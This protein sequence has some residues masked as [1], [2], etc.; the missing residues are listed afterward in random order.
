MLNVQKTHFITEPNQKTVT[1]KRLFDFPKETIF[2]AM[3]KPELLRLWYGLPENETT[4]CESDL[5]IGGAYRIVQRTSDGFEI[6]FRGEHLELAYPNHRKYTW[7]FEL[8]PDKEA[9]ITETFDTQ[10]N[11]TL[12]TAVITFA[13]VEDR[14][15][16]LKFGATAGGEA[17][18]NR[19]ENL[20]VTIDH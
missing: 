18:L 10:G 1:M 11:Q 20:L 9:V 15:N 8:M 16:Y 3:T 7:I 14:D 17:S 2:D 6:G 13:S 4:V 5:R 12:F 19:L